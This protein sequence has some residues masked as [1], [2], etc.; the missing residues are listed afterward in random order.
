MAALRAAAHEAPLAPE[1]RL[2][3]V[4]R[5]RGII[6]AASDMKRLAAVAPDRAAKRRYAEAYALFKNELAEAR[7]SP[8][9]ADIELAWREYL[10]AQRRYHEFVNLGRRVAAYEQEIRRR[11][12]ALGSQARAV[13]VG[14]KGEAERRRLVA[15]A[16]GVESRP[17]KRVELDE[18]IMRELFGADVDAGVLSDSPLGGG[19]MPETIAALEAA[20][21]EVMQRRSELWRDPMVQYFAEEA[22][23]ERIRAQVQEGRDVIE[24]PSTVRILNQMQRHEDEHPREVF[25][26]VLVGPPGTGKTTAVREYCRRTGRRLVEIDLSGDVTRYLFWGTREIVHDDPVAAYERLAKRV[27]ELHGDELTAFLQKGI[28]Q[29]GPGF[30][31]VAEEVGQALAGIDANTAA[32]FKEDLQA[33]LKEQFREDLATEVYKYGRENGWRAGLVMHAL[34]RGDAICFNEFN[35]AKDLSFLHGL[36]TARAAPKAE[37]GAEPAQERPGWFYIADAK[38]WIQLPTITG[39]DGTPRASSKLFFTANV[40]K[41]YKVSAVLG[42]LASRAEGSII[43]VDPVPKTE[44]LALMSALVVDAAGHPILSDAENQNLVLLV[45]EVFPK[46]RAFIADKEPMIPLSFRTLRNIA[47]KLVDPA[48]GRVRPGATVGRAAK[49]VLMD[50]YRLYED[51]RIPNEIARDLVTHGIISDAS[52]LRQLVAEG[53]LTDAELAAIRG[54]PGGTG[55]APAG[56][57]GTP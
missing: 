53:R 28:A 56:T 45:G 22:Q 21:G 10:A 4:L 25:G 40:G 24:L 2:A 32:K 54:T 36:L 26:S 12:L 55:P 39:P 11:S 38:Q 1:D 16:R 46:I 15:V 7:S 43:Q 20:R 49:E 50:T 35:K 18:E 52:L 42:P 48:T 41:K 27:S 51:Q 19:A 37:V 30:I 5:V 9:A 47:Q 44:E 29:F 31:G 34:Q 17:A 57:V 8:E 3:T 23:K 6:R 14:P 33:T 13:S